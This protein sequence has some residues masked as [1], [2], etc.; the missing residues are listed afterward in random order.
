MPLRRMSAA[1]EA[2]V[3]ERLR[4][5]KSK[6]ASVLIT[7]PDNQLHYAFLKQEEAELRAQVADLEA[8]QAQQ[9]A[10]CAACR[11]RRHAGR[12]RAP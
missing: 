9:R 10:S 5:A 12:A 3:G 8:L 11:L 4:V 7:F 2:D 1:P 6:L